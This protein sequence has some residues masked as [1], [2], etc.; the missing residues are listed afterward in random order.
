MKTAE[1]KLVSSLAQF[2]QGDIKG[3]A[4]AHAYRVS[5]IR[6][7][8]EQAFKGNYTPITEAATLTAGKAKKARAYHAGF[9]T[10]GADGLS[11]VNYIGKLNDHTNKAAREAIEANTH[12]ACAA[13]FVAF[14]AVMAE[15]A[16]PKAKAP[17][18]APA[19]VPVADVVDSG[20][21][22]VTDDDVRHAMAVV[23]DETVC[24]IVALINQG[25]LTGQQWN[26][27]A[28]AMEAAIDAEQTE[29][30]SADA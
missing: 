10:F 26:M 7:A 2:V 25:M 18:P 21:T 23:Q 15:K 22:E 19:P 28:E 5:V 14:D 1:I 16:E 24:K 12:N 29:R 30:E 6:S 3:G 9:A 20:D 13:F 17:A 27:I 11:K 8:I 4:H